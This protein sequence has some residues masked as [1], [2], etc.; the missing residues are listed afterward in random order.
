MARGR[1]A[2]APGPAGPV[3]AVTVSACRPG[4][5][6]AHSGG[7]LPHPGTG[8]GAGTAYSLGK[9]FPRDTGCPGRG[10]RLGGQRA[11]DS[12]VMLSAVTG[13]A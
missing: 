13:S 6:P 5:T 11:C 2:R 4:P 3:R 7:H 9:P 8:L 12:C 1:Q 10:G